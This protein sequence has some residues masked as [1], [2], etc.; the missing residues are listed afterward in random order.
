[1]ENPHEESQEKFNFS[2]SMD[3]RCDDGEELACIPE[4][5]DDSKIWMIEKFV[6]YQIKYFAIL[7]GIFSGLGAKVLSYNMIEKRFIRFDALGQ[8]QLNFWIIFTKLTAYVLCVVIMIFVYKK[9]T[10]IL[11]PHRKTHTLCTLTTR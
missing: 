7:V 9:I 6:E 5:A 3:P 2:F 10:Q 4:M 11:L 8:L 1:M